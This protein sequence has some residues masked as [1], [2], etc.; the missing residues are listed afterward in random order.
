MLLTKGKAT[1][2]NVNGINL[3]LENVE[4]YKNARLKAIDDDIDQ[5]I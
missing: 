2:K 4:Q 3:L 5:A 1:N